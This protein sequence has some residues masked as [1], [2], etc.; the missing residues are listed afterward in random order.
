MLSL[1]DAFS[2]FCVGWHLSQDIDTRLTLAALEM[3][4]QRRQPGIGLI[5][6]S[7][8][9]VQYASAAYMLRLEEAGMLPSMSAKGNPY[10]ARPR[11]RLHM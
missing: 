8:R 2:R 9:G 1:V 10:Q 11:Y 4:V 3:A 5:H 7:D 6:H